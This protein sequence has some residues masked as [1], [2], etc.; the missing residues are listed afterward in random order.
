MSAHLTFKCRF[1]TSHF[2]LIRGASLLHKALLNL[3][4]AFLAMVNY[5]IDSISEILQHSAHE[6]S[7]NFN[8]IKFYKA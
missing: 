4:G 2:R 7:S 3:I 1:Y 5:R 6:S 8:E